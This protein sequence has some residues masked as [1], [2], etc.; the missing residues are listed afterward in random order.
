M[1]S[2]AMESAMVK[3][4]HVAR[5]AEYIKVQTNSN[6]YLILNFGFLVYYFLEGGTEQLIID[7]EGTKMAMVQEITI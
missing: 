1:K 5:T 4:T 3:Q 6:L 2:S 7:K